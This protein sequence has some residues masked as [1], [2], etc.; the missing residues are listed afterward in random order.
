MIVCTEDPIGSAKKLL[1]LIKNFSKVL[2]YKSQHTHTKNQLLCTSKRQLK[3]KFLE[4][5][6]KIMSKVWNT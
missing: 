1:D 5:P 3:I 4:V 2:G 6:L